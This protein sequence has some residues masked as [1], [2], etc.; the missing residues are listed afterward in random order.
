[1]EHSLPHDTNLSFDCFPVRLSMAILH[2][3]IPARSSRVNGH[4]R[5]E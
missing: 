4:S 1:M 2:T 3:R 5:P